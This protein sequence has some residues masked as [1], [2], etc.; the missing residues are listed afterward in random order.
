VPADEAVRQV[1]LESVL[2]AWRRCSCVVNRMDRGPTG[3]ASLRQVVLDQAAELS[4]RCTRCGACQVR[5]AFLT[6]YGTPGA[7]SERLDVSSPEAAR[8]A[9]A[10]SLCDLCRPV[11]PEALDPGAWFLALRRY[12]VVD[13]RADLSRYRRILGYEKKGTS[14]LFSYYALPANCDTIFFPG[15]SLSG[16]RPQATWKMFQYLRSELPSLGI[17]L[18]C[19]TKPSHDLGRHDHFRTMFGEMTHYLRISGIKRV[20][21]ACPSCY[22]TFCDHADGF[23]VE[24]V[25]EVIDRTMRPGAGGCTKPMFGGAV[26]VIHDPCT[27]RYET[28]VQDSIRSLLAKLEIPIAEMVF[29]RQKTMCCG[30]GGSVGA[31]DAKLA[32]SWA[33]YRKQ[34]AG[35]H[36]IVT[37]CAGCTGFLNPVTPTAHIADLLFCADRVADGSLST[38]RAPF[39]YLH[40]LLFKR[41]LK[42]AMTPAITRVRPSLL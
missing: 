41:R 38:A 11:C 29:Q 21:L 8:I 33:E 22:R 17:V 19:C 25:Y 30:E 12:A 3:S 10:C 6:R 26:P 36:P 13:G 40:R 14:P 5:C 28:A 9:F 4:A 24:T 7:I 39:T 31:A 15:C 2:A 34:L 16:T 42:K 32:R 23:T 1:H 18:D 20:L 35:G 27:I 37:Y